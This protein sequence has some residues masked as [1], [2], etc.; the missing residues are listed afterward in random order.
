MSKT[1]NCVKKYKTINY[2]EKCI[3]ILDFTIDMV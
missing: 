2:E 3:G 1:T